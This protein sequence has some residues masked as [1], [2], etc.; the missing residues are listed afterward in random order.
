MLCQ[1]CESC[2][3]VDSMSIH[4]HDRSAASADSVIKGSML[5][6]G[7]C[8]GPAQ[9]IAVLGE[10]LVSVSPFGGAFDVARYNGTFSHWGAT[11]RQRTAP[12]G[13][14]STAPRSASGGRGGH[15]DFGKR[16]FWVALPAGVWSRATTEWI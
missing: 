3:S 10:R 8:R 15:I 1:I 2:E 12:F 9:P 14:G 4:E 5:A 13:P 7:A 16:C 11:P 6:D